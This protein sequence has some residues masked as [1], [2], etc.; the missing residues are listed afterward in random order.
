[1]ASENQSKNELY[2]KIKDGII[3]LNADLNSSK[4]PDCEL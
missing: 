3:G 4:L 1:M 2:E